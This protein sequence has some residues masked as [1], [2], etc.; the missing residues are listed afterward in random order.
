MSAFFGSNEFL[1][2]TEVEK[3]GCLFPILKKFHLFKKHGLALIFKEEVKLELAAY[4][5]KIQKEEKKGKQWPPSEFNCGELELNIIARFSR[6]L[7]SEVLLK[8]DHILCED[9]ELRRV[10]KSFLEEQRIYARI[11]LLEFDGKLDKVLPLLE[12]VNPDWE[13]IRK[14]EES[15]HK[16]YFQA[17]GYPT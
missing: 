8:W 7:D 3:W 13:E 5:D 10:T 12:K 11:D 17:W 15:L 4:F 6:Q 16:A 14:V 2:E 9:E 1:N